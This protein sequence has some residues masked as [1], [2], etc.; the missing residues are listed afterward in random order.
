MFKIFPRQHVP[1]PSSGALA[2]DGR[3]FVKLHEYVPASTSFYR[4]W[5]HVFTFWRLIVG[6]IMCSAVFSISEVAATHSKLPLTYLG[7]Q[8]AMTPLNQELIN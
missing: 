3:V 6:N 7:G 4:L 8:G 5:A 2:F 1:G